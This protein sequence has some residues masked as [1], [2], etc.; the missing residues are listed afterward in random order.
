MVITANCLISQVDE[1]P[2]VTPNSSDTGFDEY[3]DVSDG[4]NCNT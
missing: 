3:M 2:L 4:K 1:K